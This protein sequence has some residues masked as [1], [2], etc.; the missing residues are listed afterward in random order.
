MERAVVIAE[1]AAITIEDLPA[2][3]LYASAP[4]DGSDPAW[5]EAFQDEY[6]SSTA[7]LVPNR[8]DRQQREQMEREQ[9]V[10][11][12]ALAKGNKAE[13]ARAL[14]MARSTLF[15]RLRKYGLS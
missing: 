5:K 14:G 11:A 9:L 1:G 3:I 6:V 7:V 15:S 4:L 13:A 10:R 8:F 2:E 12:L